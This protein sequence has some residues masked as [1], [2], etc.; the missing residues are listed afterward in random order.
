MDAPVSGKGP[1]IKKV[2]HT[3]KINLV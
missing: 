1:L 2:P 3:T